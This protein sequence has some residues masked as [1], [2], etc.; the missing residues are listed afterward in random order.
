[1]NSSTF[2]IFKKTNQPKQLSTRNSLLSIFEF[3]RDPSL[4]FLK[5]IWG[6]TGICSGP[7]GFPNR[8]KRLALTH[9]GRVLSQSL[10]VMW[11]T[12]KPE[13]SQ[14]VGNE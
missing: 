10:K 6:E 11:L 5:I 4:P 9:R 14:L 13:S 7:S 2:L 3:T 1:M 8:N 12:S